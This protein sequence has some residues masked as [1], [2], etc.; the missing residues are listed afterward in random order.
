MNIEK[1]TENTAIRKGRKFAQVLE[2]AREVFLAEGFSASNMD[3]VAKASGVSKATL[4]SYFPDK[5]SMFIVVFQTECMRQAD[6]AMAQIDQSETPD[7]VLRNAGQHLLASITS[8]FGQRMFRMCVS[9][10]DRFPELGPAFYK[11]GPMIIRQTLGEYLKTATTA[12][13][14]NVTDFDLAADQFVELCKTDIFPKMM[15][16]VQTVFEKAELDRIVD[17]AVDTFLARYLA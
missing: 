9:E 17:G 7:V 10:C 6:E 5:E 13:Q 15:F 11:S 12:G 16:G 2:G 3:H 14:L 4:Y 1:N 8:E